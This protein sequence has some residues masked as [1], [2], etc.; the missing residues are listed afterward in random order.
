MTHNLTNKWILWYHDISEKDWS[1]NGYLK[2]SEFD[3]IE[4]F[5]ATYNDLNELIIQN[6]MLFLMR[7]GINP[8]WEDPNNKN[9][10]CWSFKISKNDVYKTWNDLSVHL[11]GENI[12]K[13]IDNSLNI[14]GISISPKKCF[15][16]VKIWSKN[17]K[18][19]NNY[20]SKK[21]P[22]IYIYDS[23]FKSHIS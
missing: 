13:E 11:I 7:D 15:S 9:G 4:D 18:N 23:I 3:T 16:I 2:I 14:N 6:S 17:N 8:L 5:W 20:L 21:I 10:G 19:I 1:I 12:T 22:N